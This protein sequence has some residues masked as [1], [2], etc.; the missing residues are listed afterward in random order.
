MSKV[1]L[2]FDNGPEPEVTPRVLEIMSERRL[3]TTFFVIGEKLA[4]SSRRRLAEAAHDAGHWIGNHS[5][6]HSVPLGERRERGA[7]AIEIGRA[8]E[9]LGPLSRP[10][11]LFRPFGGGGRLDRCLLSRD[12]VDYLTAGRYTCVLWNCVPHD[13][14]DPDGWVDRALKEIATRP[15]SLVVLHDLPTGA[16]RHLERFLDRLDAA[17]I[18]VVQEFPP[19]CV[20]IREGAVVLPIGAYVAEPGA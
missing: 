11:R 14:D 9:A 3:L 10:E 16:I 4:D 6:T 18:E 12:A 2:S 15:W 7:A 8:Q 20:P 13:W 1:T 17:Q 19:E 5:L